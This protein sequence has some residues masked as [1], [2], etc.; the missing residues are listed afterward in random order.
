M[1]SLVYFAHTSFSLSFSFDQHHTKEPQQKQTIGEFW[2]VT[3]KE[4]ALLWFC[5]KNLRFILS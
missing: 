1:F 4:M 2:A 5:K 3:Q